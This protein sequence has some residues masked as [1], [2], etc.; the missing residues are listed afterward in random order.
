M[1]RKDDKKIVVVFVYTNRRA[2][3]LFAVEVM[4]NLTSW[5]LQLLWAT[6]FLMKVKAEET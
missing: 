3:I 4:A 1:S 5:Y 6:Q 2:G